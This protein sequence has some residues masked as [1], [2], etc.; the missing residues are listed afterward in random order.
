MADYDRLLK[1][2]WW[3]G[4][5]CNQTHGHGAMRHEGHLALRT[6]LICYSATIC[7]WNGGSNSGLIRR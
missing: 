4:Q 1:C 6:Q 3:A 5:K 7:I 2:R